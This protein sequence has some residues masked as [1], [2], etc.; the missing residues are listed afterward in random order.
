MEA[1]EE[2]EDS[3]PE[4][5]PL[6]KHYK[7]MPKKEKAKKE[8]PTGLDAPKASKKKTKAPIGSNG[9]PKRKVTKSRVV[10][11][12]NGF[13]STPSSFISFYFSL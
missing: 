5:V 8:V 3:A 9:K 11:L 4:H 12:P 6:T 1:D 2:A 10:K 7:G 13:M